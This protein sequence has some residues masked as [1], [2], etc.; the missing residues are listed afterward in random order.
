MNVIKLKRVAYADKKCPV[1]DREYQIDGRGPVGTIKEFEKAF[2]N[3]VL[4]LKEDN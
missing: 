1:E 4:V 3:K 2:P